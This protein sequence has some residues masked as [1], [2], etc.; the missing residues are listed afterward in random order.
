MDSGLLLK[1]E[2]QLDVL[3]ILKADRGLGPE[4][5]KPI[6][7]HEPAMPA[8]IH[9]LN[10]LI[11]IPPSKP[12]SLLTLKFIRQ[13][14]I[15]R[16]DIEARLVLHASKAVFEPAS[17]R[18][19]VIIED[20]CILRMSLGEEGKG[21]P[22]MVEEVVVALDMDEPP[23]NMEVNFLGGFILPYPDVI[24]R[25]GLPTKNLDLLGQ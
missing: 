21:E 18:H 25:N 20:G 10:F 12:R 13:E 3:G 11:R 17:S 2:G 22:A 6:R 8:I 24:R 1:G 7:L 14:A 23:G 4:V 19:D 9:F 5:T 16:S 15:P